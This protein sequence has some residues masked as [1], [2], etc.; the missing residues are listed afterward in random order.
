MGRIQFFF[1]LEKL[2]LGCTSSRLHYLYLRVRWSFVLFRFFILT[3]T[4]TPGKVEGKR[5]ENH[6]ALIDS[7]TLLFSGAF[8][9]AGS[10]RCLCS[11]SFIRR[12]Y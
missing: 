10:S 7:R 4:S 8:A 2:N 9:R 12:S 11:S 1:R 3:G 5:S 6:K